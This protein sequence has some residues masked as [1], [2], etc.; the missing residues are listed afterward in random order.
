MLGVGTHVDVGVGTR[1]DVGARVG[2]KC[3]CGLTADLA[4]LA[5]MVASA[6]VVKLDL[7]L[8]QMLVAG[9]VRIEDEPMLEE[10]LG[11][12]DEDAPEL[13]Y[14]DEDVP[15]DTEDA[16]EAD[17]TENPFRDDVFEIRVKK[18]PDG[19]WWCDVPLSGWEGAVGV[20]KYGKRAVGTVSARMQAYS[21]IAQFLEENHQDLLANGPFAVQKPICKQAEL[22]SSGYF[23]GMGGFWAPSL[24][25]CLRSVDL[26]WA[27]GSLPLRRLFAE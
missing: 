4:V 21:R 2:L 12:D 11:Q 17:G 13:E 8:G 26:V 14:G 6:S 25:R 19:R 3:E 5:G 10:N 9:E 1:V 15:D 22:L 27:C 23:K 16:V 24:S 7:I 20:G 18:G